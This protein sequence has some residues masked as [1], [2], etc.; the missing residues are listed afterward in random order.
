[1][2]L[3]L[4]CRSKRSFRFQFGVVSA[5]QLF[6]AFHFIHRHGKDHRFNALFYARNMPDPVLVL[7]V[8]YFHG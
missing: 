2:V 7:K 5:L 6:L 8:D 4:R 3:L 1:M